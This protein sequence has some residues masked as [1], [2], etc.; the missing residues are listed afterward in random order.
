ME[1]NM[2][3]NL[4][5][6]LLGFT[7]MIWGTVVAYIAS[8]MAGIILSVGFLLYW[9]MVSYKLASLEKISTF[10]LLHAPTVVAFAVYLIAGQGTLAEIAYLF[11]W[12]TLGISC[13]AGL[14]VES[15]AVVAVI[16][17]LLMALAFALGRK[18]AIKE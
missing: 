14:F 12:P 18:K 2:N 10:A 5:T 11:F 8:D 6:L 9:A 1:D 4:K 16:S 15:M 7:P 3:N 13:L 17:G